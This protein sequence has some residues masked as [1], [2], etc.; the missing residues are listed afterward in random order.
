MHS[1]SYPF[2]PNVLSISCQ[3]DQFIS[4]F[5]VVGWYFLFGILIEIA[6]ANSGDNDRTPRSAVS[7]LDLHCL[8]LIRDTRFVEKYALL[9]EYLR[10]TI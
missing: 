7:D 9:P 2:E 5:K 1:R 8:Y 3:L 4:N 6:L 10:F